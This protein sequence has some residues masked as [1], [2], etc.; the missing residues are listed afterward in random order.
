MC[1]SNETLQYLS[2]D[3]AIDPITPEPAGTWGLPPVILDNDSEPAYAYWCSYALNEHIANSTPRLAS[4]E[5]PSESFLLLEA[6]DSRIDGDDLDEL[7]FG[8]SEGTVIAYHDGHVKWQRVTYQAA[9]PGDRET[10]IWQFPPGHQFAGGANDVG[11][12][13]ARADD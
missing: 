1:P 13:T 6:S 9:D 12:W 7:F 8:H 11:G 3:E 4:W 2:N 10:W 5:A